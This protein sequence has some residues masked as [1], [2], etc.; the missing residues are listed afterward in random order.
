[1][2]Y[3][4]LPRTLAAAL[5]DLAEPK[6]AVRVAALRDLMAYVEADRAAVLGGLEQAVCDTAAEVRARAAEAIGDAGLSEGLPWLVTMANDES[7]LARQYAIL[8]P[9]PWLWSDHT[10]QPPSPPLRQ[11]GPFWTPLEKGF[12][13][14]LP[15]KKPRSKAT[16]R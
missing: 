6:P 2:F 7:A 9:I 1:M 13:R 3:S 12:E 15:G 11:L 14:S 10:P 5:R 16:R 8:A 4:P